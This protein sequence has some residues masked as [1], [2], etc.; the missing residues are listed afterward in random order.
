[1]VF[2]LSGQL[3]LDLARIQQALGADSRAAGFF[4]E[5]SARAAQAQ[6][7]TL[8]FIPN[9]AVHIGT[10]NGEAS[11]I[12]WEGLVILDA[13]DGYYSFLHPLITEL[14]EKTGQLID[15]WGDATFKEADLIT[16]K[17]TINGAINLVASQPPE[18]DVY[19]GDHC[20]YNAEQQ[21]IRDP[22]YTKVSNE[23]FS[24]LLKKFA[25]LIERAVKEN[26]S[27]VCI[28]D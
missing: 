28:G 22:M 12:N 3:N 19:V 1:L 26:G 16:L 5:V 17:D 18:W 2:I 9:M 7:S 11:S 21:F 20:H 14:H 6:R 8:T 13:F 15:P 24:D 23:A 25:R 10:S 27:V 4:G